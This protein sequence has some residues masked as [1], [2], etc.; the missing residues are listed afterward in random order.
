MP[1]TKTQVKKALMPEEPDYCKASQLGPEAL[2]HLKGFITG[3]DEAL[4]SK[5]T[6]LAGLIKDS[7]IVDILITAA[8][9]QS[10]LVRI[11]AAASAKHLKASDSSK[12]LDILA[13]DASY[14]V[15]KMVLISAPKNPSPELVNKIKSIA[16]SDPMRQ[17]RQRASAVLEK[18]NTN[19]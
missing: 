5:A 6:Y 2:P 9:S 19:P 10:D 14:G 17:L 7:K 12:I 18:L 13:N 1:V 16:S 3:K 15:R 4:A 11:A 8:A